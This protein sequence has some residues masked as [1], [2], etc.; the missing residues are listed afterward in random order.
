VVQ[1]SPGAPRGA[2]PSAP[3]QSF[4]GISFTGLR[5][6]DTVGDV[7]PSH[8]VQ[9]VN[10]AFAIY[11]RQGNLLAGP[12]P[13]GSIWT[14]VGWQGLCGLDTLI[15]PIVVYDQAADRF[16]LAAFPAVSLPPFVM[17]IAVSRTGNPVTGGFYAYEF[18]T[19]ELPDYEKFGIWPDA[20]YMSTFEDP[21]LGAYAFD[22]ARMLNG[23]PATFQRFA[24]SALAGGR[25]T[26]ILPSDWDGV[27]PPPIG[28]PNY[29]VR[30]VDGE[31]HGGSDRLEV[32][33]FHVDWA[34]PANSS[35]TLATTLPT[36][37][38][39]TQLNCTPT[40]RDCIP[41]PNTSQRLDDLAN[42]LMWRLQYRNYGG[43]LG[44]RM[45]T[46]QTVDAD[47]NGLAGI[48]FYELR[49][50]GSAW[51]IFQQG[52]YAP[53]ANYRWMGSTAM[54]R[55]NN[56]ALGYSIVNGL[57]GAG[58]L[59]PSI[60]YTG[61]TPNDPPGTFPGPE[62]T[63]FNGSGSQT[64][65][66]RWGD[67]SAMSVDPVDDCTFWYTQEYM[68]ANGDWRTRIGSFRC[69]SCAAPTPTPTPTATPTRTATPTSTPTPTRTPLPP[70]AGVVF[71]PLPGQTT[72]GACSF[73]STGSFR[74][75]CQVQNA[76][77]PAVITIPLVGGGQV[78]LPCGTTGG[79][80][81]CNGEFV[82][83]VQ[84][85]GQA[86]VLVNGAVVAQGTVGPG[87][88]GFPTPIAAAPPLPP[89]VPPPVA[90]APPLPPPALP[91][92]PLLPPLLPPV[93]A[94]P[95]GAAPPSAGG[96]ILEVPVIPEGSPGGLVVVGLLGLA[97][98]ARWRQRRRDEC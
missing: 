17:C 55:D 48:R 81:A 86:S 61:R 65:G 7:G 50:A 88:V 82:G 60:R 83:A 72:N 44:E 36:A 24:I 43:A 1:R 78:Q 73:T 70:P 35:F 59:F 28:S 76:A 69:P 52:T 66:A 37:P 47:G 91:P 98:L 80:S 45:V 3:L 75:S 8:Y 34:T 31:V 4:E 14:A 49:K 33:Q 15:D 42:R 64:A 21:D 32:Y 10:S 20:Y 84:V 89:V 13:I 57:G 18:V 94:P 27:T 46:N 54:D 40:F 16:L 62:Q 23:Q 85:G 53:D 71:N 41:Q 30:S 12:S 51:T 29:F 96:A 68:P 90:V 77:G 63:L 26:R 19:P 58:A 67:Y 22:R 92:L 95:V 25:L 5:P 97:L 39:D 74:A 11:D 38:F 6:P 87:A 2:Q 9:M 56:I 93:G 79:A